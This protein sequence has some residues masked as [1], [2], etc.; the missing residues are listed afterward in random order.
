MTFD[1]K[2][3]NTTVFETRKSFVEVPSLAPF[4]GGDKAVWEVRNLSGL[5]L[6]TAREKMALAKVVHGLASGI[7][8]EEESRKREA[9][10]LLMGAQEAS[11]APNEYVL[12]LHLAVAGSVDPK[13]DMPTA[14]RLATT[15]PIDFKRIVTEIVTLSDMG[16]SI[17][18]K[19]KPSGTKPG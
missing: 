16:A 12:H 8:G 5:E 14:V 10:K 1:T 4:F 15:K 19:R 3:F 18:E 7:K 11:G 9:L 2:K 13:I 6:A 17:V